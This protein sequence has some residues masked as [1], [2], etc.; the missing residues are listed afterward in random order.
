MELGIVGTA[1]AIAS[2]VHHATGLRVRALPIQLDQAL[3]QL[4]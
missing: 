3:D 1:A 4:G 2:A